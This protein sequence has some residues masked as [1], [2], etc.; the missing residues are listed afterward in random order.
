MFNNTIISDISFND[1]KIITYLNKNII[2][3][4][5]LIA[6]DGKKSFVK[7]TFKTPVFNKNYKKKALVINLLHS[8]NHKGTAFEFFYKEGPLAI[9]PMQKLNN[10][11]TKLQ[12][13][14]RRFR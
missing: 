11:L 7:N 13:K 3:A 2:S 9:L 6:A 12:I 1:D 4:D 5:L 8:I 10:T 14:H